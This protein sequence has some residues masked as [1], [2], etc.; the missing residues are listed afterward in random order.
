MSDVRLKIWGR[1][2]EMPVVFDCYENEDVLPEQRDA[3]KRLLD[4][5]EIE[6][7]KPAV[8]K[9]CLDMNRQEI[10]EQGI[11]NI[12]KYVMPCGLYVRRSASPDRYVGLMCKY[13]FNPEDG[14]AILFKNEAL[15]D[16]G[17]S[18]IL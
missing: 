8:E 18:D 14:L 6:A 15:C 7:S 3:L 16:I 2:L 11:T 17:T 10:G 12:F 13:R 4:T 5:E 9:Y 1:E